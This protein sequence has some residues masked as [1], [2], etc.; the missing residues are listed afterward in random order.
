ML[1]HIKCSHKNEYELTYQL[2]CQKERNK[3]KMFNFEL[4]CNLFNFS[5]SLLFLIEVKMTNFVMYGLYKI[6]QIN[7]QIY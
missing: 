3:Q 6:E 4:S 7:D 2:A 5:F 1:I